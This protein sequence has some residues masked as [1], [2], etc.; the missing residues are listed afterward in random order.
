MKLLFYGSD[1]KK[2]NKNMIPKSIKISVIYFVI[3][4][5][6]YACATNLKEQQEA[7]SAPFDMVTAEEAVE[8]SA[9]GAAPDL[10]LEYEFD[11]MVLSEA[12]LNAFELRA[13]E[14]L[15]DITE[16]VEIISNPV[17]DSLFRLQAKDMITECFLSPDSKFGGIL[18]TVIEDK[19]VPV[20]K[21][22]E[23]LLISQFKIGIKLKNISVSHNL[24]TN[25]E[26][27]YRGEMA[28]QSQSYIVEMGD[29]AW[30]DVQKTSAEI[31][32]KMIKKDFGDITKDIWDVF[33]GDVTVK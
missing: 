25:D 20:Q 16:Y 3:T 24:T 31:V 2:Q 30:A 12:T 13:I 8:K 15:K 6:L 29:T 11:E 27:L 23:A 4:I 5:C 26:E 21:C 22:V 17:Y 7:D 1:K 14:K 33:I 10:Q 9:T 32:V 28:F 19:N 18:H